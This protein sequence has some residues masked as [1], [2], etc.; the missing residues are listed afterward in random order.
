M[1]IIIGILF[2]LV[3]ISFVLGFI[4]GKLNTVD[5]VSLHNRPGNNSQKQSKN[6]ISIDNAKFV[7]DIKLDGIEKKYTELGETKTSN[8]NIES[9]VNKL[10]SMK[11]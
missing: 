3:F 5:G 10:K 8:T 7:T 11:G 6:K 4:V 1:N 2:I 9:S